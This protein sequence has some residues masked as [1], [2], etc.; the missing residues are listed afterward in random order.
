MMV[1][2]AQQ[3]RTNRKRREP[4]CTCCDWNQKCCRQIWERSLARVNNA[5]L[6]GRVKREAATCALSQ[7]LLLIDWV[8]LIVKVAGKGDF[9]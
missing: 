2:F 9:F 6:G 5:M 3:T 8:F 7:R 1:E 4:R